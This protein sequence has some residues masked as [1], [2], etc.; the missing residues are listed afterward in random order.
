MLNGLRTLTGTGAS[1]PV[2]TAT[3]RPLVLLQP[4]TQ[5]RI[6]IHVPSTPQEWIAAEVAR[7]TFQDWIHAA[8]KDGHLVGFDAAEVDDEESSSGGNDQGSEKELVLT[9]YFLS[10]V[11]GL[12]P[13]PATATSPATAAVLL[14]AFSHFTSTYLSSTDIHSLA[15]SL[16][17][18]VR[19]LL[20]SSFYIARS[21]LENAGLAKS[22]PKQIE[23]ALLKKAVNGESELYALFGGQGMNEVYFDEL[24]VSLY[25]LN[26]EILELELKKIEFFIF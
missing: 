5:T 23:S 25:P 10:H 22:L 2:H 4:T 6:S 9:A 7:D 15:A 26:L 11:A 3:T 12:L 1:T 20:V 14:A 8:N 21:K 13:F 16:P 17:A 19:A 18:P 24:Q